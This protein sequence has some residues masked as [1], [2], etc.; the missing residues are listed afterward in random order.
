MSVLIKDEK[1]SGKHNEIWKEVRNL[2]KQK[3][4]SKNLILEKST[5][6]FTIIK[7]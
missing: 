5:L 6:I 1:L 4:D 7:N 3:T 2:I